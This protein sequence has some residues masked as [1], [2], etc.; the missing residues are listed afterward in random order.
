[1]PIT[2]SEKRLPAERDGGS[3]QAKTLAL[4]NYPFDHSE[5][6]VPC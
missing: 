3:D 5:A 6:K 1:M 4:P 2:F